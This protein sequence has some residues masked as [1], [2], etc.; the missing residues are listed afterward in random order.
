MNVGRGTGQDRSSLASGR[1]WPVLFLISI[2]RM[3]HPRCLRCLCSQEVLGF[4]GILLGS[5]GFNSESAFGWACLVVFQ[6]EGLGPFSKTSAWGMWVGNREAKS[7][8]SLFPTPQ[9]LLGNPDGNPR[10][11]TSR[12]DLPLGSKWFWLQERESIP[13]EVRESRFCSLEE[14]CP[15]RSQK[16]NR[17]TADGEW[18]L[19]R[20]WRLSFN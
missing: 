4:S 2:C 9:G 6:K 8:A 14:C 17:E 10:R 1:V 15:R 5:N 3:Q 11:D 7:L 18:I 13:E 20:I 16:K 12:T 19:A